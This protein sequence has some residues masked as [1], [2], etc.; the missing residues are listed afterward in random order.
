M[1]EQRKEG[2]F[3]AM[4][5]LINYNWYTEYKDHGD[6]SITI[7]KHYRI[8]IKDPNHPPEIEG[9]IRLHEDQARIVYAATINTTAHEIVD[10]FKCMHRVR[11]PMHIFSYPEI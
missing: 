3:T 8:H 2:I 10:G 1:N 6:G 11:N 4:E 9:S 5:N 7:R